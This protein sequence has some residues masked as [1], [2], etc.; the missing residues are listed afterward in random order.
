MVAHGLCWTPATPCTACAGCSVSKLDKYRAG[1]CCRTTATRTTTCPTARSRTTSPARPS[2]CRWR[3]TSRGRTPGGASSP[4]SP[5]ASPSWAARATTRRAPWLHG[6][7]CC[8][9]CPS[10][11]EGGDQ[12]MLAVPSWCTG[13][14]VHGHMGGCVEGSCIA[15]LPHRAPPSARA[16]LRHAHSVHSVPSRQPGLEHAGS[17]SLVC[18]MLP[19]RGRRAPTAI[20]AGSCAPQRSKDPAQ[21]C[22]CLPAHP[23]MPVLVRAAPAGLS[24]P[25]SH[26]PLRARR[27]SCR[28]TTRP[29]SR[30]GCR[31]SSTPGGR[32]PPPPRA[33]CHAALRRLSCALPRCAALCCVPLAAACLGRSGVST[34]GPVVAWLWIP[35]RHP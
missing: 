31:A 16:T 3:P 19:A 20:C 30:P 32:A 21:R 26:G 2:T 13:S 17:A 35:C 10:V 7:P 25:G 8:T 29:T 18:C 4:P 5:R 14:A 15:F 1:C 9:A 22:H 28:A 12:G 6:I 27:S 33:P 34:V 23:R 11:A 24:A